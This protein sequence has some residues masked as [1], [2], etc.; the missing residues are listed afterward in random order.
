MQKRGLLAIALLLISMNLVS[1]QASLG[2]FL[3]AFGWENMLLLGTFLISFVLI[4]FILTRVPV[5]RDRMT[6]QTNKAVPGI[7]A[8]ILSLFIVYGIYKWEFD[9]EGMFSGFG[10]GIEVLQTITAI[11]ILLGIAYLF[12]KI[13][14][15]IF[16]IIGILLII[17]SFTDWIYETS[18]VFFAGVISI[19]IWLVIRIFLKKKEG[20]GEGSSYGIRGTGLA[21]GIASGSWAATKGIASG[22]LAAARKLEE[23]R[24]RKRAE[25][26]QE[27]ERA[28]QMQTERGELARREQEQEVAKQK[29]EQNKQILLESKEMKVER[30]RKARKEVLSKVHPDKYQDTRE[31][32]LANRYFTEINVVVE[33]GSAEKVYR[34]AEEFLGRLDELRKVGYVQSQK[35]KMG[36]ELKNRYIVGVEEVLSEYTPLE[37][38]TRMIKIMQGILGEAEKL[39]IPAEI[40]L[41]R[42]FGNKECNR[43]GEY[44]GEVRKRVLGKKE[45]EEQERQ[46]QQKKEE[47]RGEEEMEKKKEEEKFKQL[48]KEKK[49]LELFRT[50][51]LDQVQRE[52]SELIQDEQNFANR[53]ISIEKDMRNIDQQGRGASK[54]EQELLERRYRDLE[55][56]RQKLSQQQKQIADKR[57]ETERKLKENLA[58]FQEKEREIEEEYIEEETRER[59]HYTKR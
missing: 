44:A 26:S 1:A 40:F 38:A 10:I 45:R 25:A 28:R 3:D 24:D 42:K 6:G 21:K 33:E 31:K 43:P 52:V 29:Q 30:A 37:D 58:Y 54:G 50:G 41:S 16:L 34:L 11:V 2:G 49:E 13:K 14:S 36:E 47:L 39:G 27:E 59:G 17:L 53:I 55:S 9:I 56:Q 32:E 51:S 19:G 57:I 48:E 15:W 35:E 7:I 12:M 46:T 23:W 5:F 20:F 4:N 18:M 22:G 8:L